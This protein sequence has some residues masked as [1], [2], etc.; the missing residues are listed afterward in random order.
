MP[1]V[2]L[3]HASVGAG[4]KRA[5]QALAKAFETTYP[6]EVRVEDVLDHTPRLFRRA[7]VRSYLKL[8]DQAPLL[9]GY[10]YTSTNEDPE[11]AEVSNNIRKAVEGIGTAGLNKLL[12]SFQPDVII[13]TH[14]LPIELLVKLRRK[15]R[16]THPVYCVI[17]DYGA[18]TFWTYTEIDGYFVATK[19]VREQL[20][21]RGV[22]R[23]IIHESG[24]PIDP[25]VT[26]DKQRDVLRKHYALPFDTPVITLFGGGMS[27]EHVRVIAEGLLRSDQA[28]L[29]V[30]VAGR[31]ETLVE[32]L[33]DLVPGPNMGVRVLGFISYVDDLI[34]SSDLVVT[35]AGGLIISEVLARGIPLVVIEPIPGQEEWNADF[36]VM[37]GAGIQLRIAES[38]A[39]A[40][41]RLL[42]RPHLL[43]EMRAGATQV[44]RPRAADDIAKQIMVRLAEQ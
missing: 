20:M 9:W 1:R 33:A 25:E 26:C 22:S 15:A 7:Y 5:A 44:A 24:I 43:A 35:K 18:H 23:L 42:Q 30:I 29:L 16:F 19:Q 4:H 28:G 37:S 8:T 11:L 38:V 41:Q 10:F 17:T 13:C 34:V 27:N 12:K 14:F 39:P 3:L 21:Q 36:V 32:S 31:N 2:L 6:G 40:V